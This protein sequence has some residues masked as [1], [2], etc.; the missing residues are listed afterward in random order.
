MEKFKF[1]P[2]KWAPFQDR[3]ICEKIRNIKKEDFAKHPTSALFS[4]NKLKTGPAWALQFLYYVRC[5]VSFNLK[6]I[7]NLSC[8]R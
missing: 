2:S 4:K 8:I 1:N 7:I 6:N 3:D 5:Y